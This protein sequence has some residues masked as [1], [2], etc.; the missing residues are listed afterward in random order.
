MFRAVIY[1]GLVAFALSSKGNALLQLALASS[2]ISIQKQR[3][4]FQNYQ[5]QEQL[6]YWV[7]KTKCKQM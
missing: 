6:F 4:P 1:F 5:D 7:R 2:I 3:N